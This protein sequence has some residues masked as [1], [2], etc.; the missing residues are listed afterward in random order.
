MRWWWSWWVVEA[1]WGMGHGVSIAKYG[2]C[3]GGQGEGGKQMFTK[4]VTWHQEIA[5]A[6]P[7]FGVRTRFEPQVQV[8]ARGKPKPLLEV[9]F[10]ETLNMDPEPRVRF[11]FEPGSRGSRT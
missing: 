4:V 3:G 9:R 2:C 11:R 10:T 6:S 7:P 1:W 8:Q 5:E